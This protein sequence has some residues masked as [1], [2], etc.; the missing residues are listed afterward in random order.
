MAEPIKCKRIID[1]KTYNT[2]TATEIYGWTN[3]HGHGYNAEHLFQSRFGAFFKY[4]AN[5]QDWNP[6]GDY[7][8]IVPV[9][10]EDARAWLEKHMSFDPNGIEK[11]FGEMPEAGSGEVKYTLRMP[12]SLR[13]KLSARAEENKQSLNAWIVRCLEGCAKGGESP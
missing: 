11:L 2:E 10:P 7:E 12:E 3:A 9:T 8:K 6:E 4:V 13:N 5:Q 1:G